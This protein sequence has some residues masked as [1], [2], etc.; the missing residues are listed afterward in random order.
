MSNSPENNEQLDFTAE[1][2]LDPQQWWDYMSGLADAAL[3]HNGYG[4]IDQDSDLQAALWYID[5]A[6]KEF[7]LERS[8][9]DGEVIYWLTVYT[10]IDGIE[11]SGYVFSSNAEGISRVYGLDMT[12]AYNLPDRNYAMEFLSKKA[13]SYLKTTKVKIDQDLSLDLHPVPNPLTQAEEVLFQGVIVAFV[14]A[15]EQL[16]ELVGRLVGAGSVG[17]VAD[18]EISALADRLKLSYDLDDEQVFSAIGR[19]E[20]LIKRA[21]I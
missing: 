1:I 4:C 12:E 21:S 6:K 18:D 11:E 15:D 20:Q 19:C 2:R 17:V 5:D 8:K 13:L 10:C 14:A 7:L 3:S 9:S 16:V